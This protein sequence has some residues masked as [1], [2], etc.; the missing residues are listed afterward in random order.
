RKEKRISD[1]RLWTETWSEDAQMWFYHNA[2]TG[3]G[4][5]APPSTG[6]TKHDGALVLSSGEVVTDPEEGGWL[7]IAMMIVSLAGRGRGVHRESDTDQA[8]KQSSCVECEQKRSTRKCDQCG[9]GFCTKCFRKT[10]ATGRRTKHTWTHVGP[11]ECAECEA[12][13]KGWCVLDLNRIS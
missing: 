5:K 12:E 8:R 9:D 11:M 10:H 4:M 1:A 7:Y 13:V 2:A 6:Y 3:K